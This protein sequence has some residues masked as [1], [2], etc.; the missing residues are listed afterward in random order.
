ME[1]EKD[2]YNPLTLTIGFWA[3]ALAALA[4]IVFALSFVTLTINTPGLTTWTGLDDYVAYATSNN[5][6]WQ[7]LARLM[8]L[9]FA[10]LFLIAVN[11]V[12]DLTTGA[13]R[14]LT[15]IALSC[16]IIFATLVSVHY[17]VQLSTVRLQVAAGDTAGLEQ[18]VQA[19][20]TS[21]IMAINMLGWT[22]FL[23]LA[24]LFVAPVFRGERLQ[25]LIRIAFV[26][27]GIA[28][29]LGAVGFVLQIIVLIYL[30]MNLLM[31]GAV[32]LAM[33]ALALH[34]RRLA[35]AQ[36]ATTAPLTT[37]GAVAE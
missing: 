32:T 27:N 7:Q 11:A 26:V 36:T 31:G 14:I 22:L 2:R 35:R 3:A 5:L 6:F 9:L 34:F 1:R 29:L 23:G 15:R 33:A 13:E 20:A 17:F 25:R 8:S 30:T 4:M 12:H 10:P 21:A 37:T 18:F 28:C 24:S 19:N 16:A